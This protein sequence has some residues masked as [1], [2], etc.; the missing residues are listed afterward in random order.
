[1]IGVEQGAA[2]SRDPRSSLPVPTTVATE[3]HQAARDDCGWRSSKI[4]PRHLERQAEVYLRQSTPHQMAENRE[5]LARQYALPDRAARLGWPASRIMQIDQDLGLSGRS[6]EARHGF[7]RLLADVAQGR[8]GLVL[9]LEMSR[10]ARNSRDWHNLFDLCAVRDVLLADEDG[11]YDPSDINDRLVLGMKG[12]M[13]EMELHMMRNRL[14]RGRRNKAQRGELFHSLPWGFVLLPDGTVALDPDEQVRATV[15]RLF[16][17]FQTLGTAYGVVRDL[18]RHDVKL[19]IREASGQLE[20]R[21]AT[22]T[23]VM[24]AL[25]HPLYAGAYAW[26]RRYTE[27]RVDPSGRITRSRKRIRPPMEWTVLLHDRA[28][29]YITWDRYL[30]NQRLLLENQRRPATKG[31]PSG[32]SALLAGLL[33]CGRCGRRLHA[34]YASIEQGRYT[35][36]RPRFEP[37]D[38][39]CGGLPARGLD[40]LV[41][42]QVLQALSPA[43]IDLSLRAIEHTS[44][45]RRQQEAQLQQNMDRAAYE[46]RRAERQ[47]HAVEPENRLVA[48]SLEQRWETALGHERAAQEAH[49]RFQSE[50]PI[51]L[52]HEERRS[53]EELSR[54]IPAL[55][56]SPET[57]PRQRQE[58]VR[59]LVERV[60]ITV[61]P[62]KQQVDVAICWAGGQESRHEMRRTVCSYEQLDDFES[63]HARIAEMRRAGWRSPRIAEQL[64][65]EG[66]RT[67]KQCAGFTAELV[68]KIFPRLGLGAGG[69]SGTDS[70]PPQW[71]ADALAGRLKIPVDKLKDWVRRGWVRA[72]QRPFGGVWI[73]HADEWDLKLLDRRVALSQKGRHYPPE[74]ATASRKE[75][76]VADKA[77]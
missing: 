71:S 30:E 32:G 27:T 74:L 61:S 45:Q 24:T 25:H 72:I 54:D 10:L 17:A 36:T 29:A 3:Q 31:R 33:H 42:G 52:T 4:K 8:V 67:P 63:L 14:E 53:L 9:A 18:R 46:A 41:A 50:K 47:Y 44:E 68:R 70:E 20:W 37:T 12:I 59:C 15:Q 2:S 23:I 57:T 19:P 21:L 55:W 26:G 76:P 65:V 69:K 34:S 75:D 51:E 62:T 58:I 40:E 16:D 28:P 5:S 22:P 48:R 13:S 7:Q 35:C 64:N 60:T 73:L 56:R 66:F 77:V 49:D 6:S 38:E 11:I 43:A 1:M 39:I